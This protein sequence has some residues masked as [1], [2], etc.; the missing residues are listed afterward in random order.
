VNTEPE[1]FRV[2]EAFLD[3]AEPMPLEPLPIPFK[4]TDVL[5]GEHL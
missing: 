4:E 1:F 2:C 3:H 5:A